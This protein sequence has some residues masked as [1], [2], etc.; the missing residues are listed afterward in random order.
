M[1]IH[2]LKYLC[3]F[4]IIIYELEA[5]SGTRAITQK[6]AEDADDEQ[7]LEEGLEDH[8]N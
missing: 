6:I 7:F 4:V 3:I 2:S 5:P 8:Q 1:N